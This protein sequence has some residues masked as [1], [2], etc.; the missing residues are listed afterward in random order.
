MLTACI[1]TTWYMTYKC[2]K[3]QLWPTLD[4]GFWCK[5]LYIIIM[6]ASG[7]N[8]AKMISQGCRVSEFT[9][10]CS[11]MQALAAMIWLDMCPFP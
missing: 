3:N 7:A 1:T 11:S 10:F 4:S 6:E 5:K 2:L 8:H 9:F